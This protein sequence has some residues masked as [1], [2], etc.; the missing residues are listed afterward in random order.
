MSFTPPG[1]LSPLFD[2]PKP[3]LPVTQGR[4]T[5]FNADTLANTVEVAGQPLLDLAVLHDAVSSLAADRTVLLVA[6]GSEYVIVGRVRT[7]PEQEE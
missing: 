6:L 2:R 5:A 1:D 3:G 7:P 4:L